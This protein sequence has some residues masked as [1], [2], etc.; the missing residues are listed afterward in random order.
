MPVRTAIV[1]ARVHIRRV[2]RKP[3]VVQKLGVGRGRD[4]VVA[5]FHFQK[6]S[7]DLSNLLADDD[8]ADVV[9]MFGLVEGVDLVPRGDRRE[10]DVRH[11]A[12]G[13]ITAVN[14]LLGV[15]AK[16]RAD[17]EDVAHGWSP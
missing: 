14:E 2:G 8:V 16:L 15:G 6:E 7:R 10:F 4:H 3:T 13:D 11:P 17:A 9:G 1:A 12:D 5:R